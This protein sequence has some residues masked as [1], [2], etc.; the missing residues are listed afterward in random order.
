[1]HLR[2]CWISLAVVMSLNAQTTAEAFAA[3]C[4]DQ[5]FMGAVSIRHHG[6]PVFES[7]CGTANAE[8]NVANTID[9]KFRIASI[10]KQFTAASV[11]LLQQEGK[12]KVQAAIGDFVDDLPAAWRTATIHQLLTHTSGIPNYTDEPLRQYDRLGATPRELLA[13]VKD[14][15]LMFPH[16][17]KMAYN[18]MGY[19]LLGMLIEKVSGIP[20]AQFVQQRLLSP[21]QMKDTGFDDAK[22]V[23]AKRAAGY[24]RTTS[25]KLENA[26]PVEAS[27]PWSA[28]GF[29]STT[30]DLL[31]WGAAV[32][33]G[34]VLN[35]QS[36][37]QM[38]QIYPETLQQGMHYGYAIVIAERL[39]RRLW[40]HGGGITGFNS[41]LQMYPDDDLNIAILS[42][43]DESETNGT[44]P[45]WTVADLLAATILNPKKEHKSR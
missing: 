45:S 19:V 1:M 11:L 7:A 40:Y 8:W 16:G 37:E 25:K 26:E 20:Y 42:N 29:Y 23:L 17:T 38:F 33:S 5:Q 9:T 6:K 22:L 44:K 28:G 4:A 18:N 2:F 21:L 13:I 3:V 12:L 32:Q 43:L 36:M 27:V 34:A 30:R 10:S 31:T 41:V 14:K 39:G 24:Q 15:P 35:K